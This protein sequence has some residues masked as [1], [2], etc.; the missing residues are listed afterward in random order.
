MPNIFLSQEFG[1][2]PAYLQRMKQEA[3]EEARRWEEEQEAEKRRKE[4]MILTQ[5][6]KDKI[7]QVIKYYILCLTFDC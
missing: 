7:L 3:A 1:R 6:E 2:T 5:E 4:S